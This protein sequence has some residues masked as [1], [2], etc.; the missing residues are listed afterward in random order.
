MDKTNIIYAIELQ[1]EKTRI[2]GQEREMS[3][4]LTLSVR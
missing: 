1:T 3:G 2:K 4:S